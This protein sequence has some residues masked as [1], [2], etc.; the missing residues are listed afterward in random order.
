MLVRGAAGDGADVDRGIGRV[1]VVGGGGAGALGHQ[2][3]HPVDQA[4]GGHHR[5]DAGVEQAR[6]HLVAADLGAEAPA[7][8][9]AGDHGE[10]GGLADDHRF[11]AGEGREHRLDHRRGA[12]AAD[13]LVVAERD[14]DGAGE[15][16]RE[17]LGDERERG[18]GEALHVGGAAAVQAAGALGQGPGVGGPGLAS[19]GNHVAVAGE[20]DAARDRRADQ[21]EE[22]G[23]LA[24]GV[25]HAGAGDAVA[26]E[27]V[28]DEA[29]EIE[30]RAGGD[31]GKGDQ[32][33]QHLARGQPQG[34]D[35][36]SV[37]A[38][39]RRRRAQPQT[40]SSRLSR[41]IFCCLVKPMRAGDPPV[42]RSRRTAHIAVLRGLTACWTDPRRS[43]RCRIS[44][45]CSPPATG[46]SMR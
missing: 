9:L 46:R 38:P 40:G 15:V 26:G 1:E 44:G 36:S 37:T 32:A 3:R 17:H 24:G 2:A 7:A 41:R 29:D 35:R 30:V 27:I 20:D 39:I 33:G 12:E 10:A 13:L 31:R 28:F 23:L 11:R 22:R 25:G 8:L 45:R 6:M 43:W 19:N 16:G 42:R 14:D 4:C 34:H 5:R 18:G 21:R